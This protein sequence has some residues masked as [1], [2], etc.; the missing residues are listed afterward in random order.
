MNLHIFEAVEWDDHGGPVVVCWYTDNH[1][2]QAVIRFSLACIERLRERALH[3][4][5]AAPRPP[6]GPGTPGVR[7]PPAR[8]AESQG[9]ASLEA[10]ARMAWA[11]GAR[12]IARMR[13]ATGMG[14]SAAQSWVRTLKAEGQRG[15]ATREDVS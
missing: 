13:A 8:R 10:V 15:N 7:T 1:E 12:S 11:R 5:G 14:Q 6:T 9:N 3:A 2:Q 4:L